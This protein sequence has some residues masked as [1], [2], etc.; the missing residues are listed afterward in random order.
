M[1]EDEFIFTMDDDD[2]EVEFI[3]AEELTET[4]H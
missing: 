4:L 1:D 2:L 3:P